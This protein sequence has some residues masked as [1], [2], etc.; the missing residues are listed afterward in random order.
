MVKKELK[1]KED[2]KKTG[3]FKNGQI[4]LNKKIQND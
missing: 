4:F 3:F 1:L 2:F